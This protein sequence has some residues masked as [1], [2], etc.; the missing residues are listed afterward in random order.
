MIRCPQCQAE[1]EE[2]KRFCPQ[3]GARLTKPIDD[4]GKTLVTPPAPS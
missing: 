3:C 2:G 1:L 4:S